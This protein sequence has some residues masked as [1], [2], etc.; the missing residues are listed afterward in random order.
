MPVCR[1]ICLCTPST[2]P[3]GMGAT[4]RT[5]ALARPADRAACEG[6]PIRPAR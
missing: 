3:S 1:P 5:H 4:L 2:D 6:A